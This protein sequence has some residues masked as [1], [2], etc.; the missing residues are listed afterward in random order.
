MSEK[1][2][3]KPLLTPIG[4]GELVKE[5]ATYIL[6]S[7]LFE[8][9]GNPNV[10]IS[11]SPEKKHISITLL[12]MLRHRFSQTLK[13]IRN[14]PNNVY[15]AAQHPPSHTT[16]RGDANIWSSSEIE[17]RS[18]MRTGDTCKWKDLN[19]RSPQNKPSN[20]MSKKLKKKKHFKSPTLPKALGASNTVDQATQLPKQSNLVLVL[21]IN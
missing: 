6:W 1:T 13:L 11:S 4:L 3:V 9:F 19:P 17:E 14:G 15:Q 8:M 10:L 16:T 18:I 2:S 7:K 21:S 5:G 20:T 12:S